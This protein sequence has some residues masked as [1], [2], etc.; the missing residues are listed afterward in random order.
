MAERLALLGG[1]PAFERTFPIIRPSADE[2]A[3]TEVLE[4]MEKVLRSNMLSN[5]GVYVRQF[6]EALEKELRVDHVIA[7]SSCTSG[8][9]LVLH[10]L[11]VRNKRMALPSFTFSATGLAGFWNGA[12]L[13]F[14]DIDQ[15]FTMNPKRVEKLPANL[16]ALV[17]VHMYGNPCDVEALGE[18]ADRAR[19]PIVYDAAHALGSSW[20]DRPIGGFGTAEV[21]SLSPTKLITTGEG[22]FI[23]TNDT[24]LAETLR[25]LRNYGNLPDYTMDVPGLNAR[26][27]EINAVLGLEM[28]SQLDRYVESRNRYVERYKKRLST[29]LG[30]SFQ[31]MRKRSRSSHKDFSVVVDP[32]QF[33]MNRDELA[34]SLEAENIS[35]KKYFYPPLHRLAAFHSNEKGR[36]PVTEQVSNNIL[37]LPIHNAMRLQD[38]DAITERI[39]MIQARASEIV[40]RL[41]V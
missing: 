13:Q 40:K 9:I 38:I 29:I 19:V 18:W 20:H 6:E 7:V 4:R 15:T 2:F 39:A 37:S 23:A 31:E 11:G 33:G 10:A 26:L 35:T 30:I 17:P 16:G 36:L 34:R 1:A 14:V 25:V 41:A 21:F 24:G 3:S 32:A 12:H 5:V 22:G 28:L 27:S 8:L